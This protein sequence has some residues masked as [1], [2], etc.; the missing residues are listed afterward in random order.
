MKKPAAAAS[1]GRDAGGPRFEQE[2]RGDLDW[3][4]EWAQSSCGIVFTDDKV[5]QLRVRVRT[6]CNQYA[7]SL[8]EIR[9]QVQRG[10]AKLTLALADAVSTNYTFFLRE[11]EIFRLLETELFGRLPPG[12]ELRFWSAA[13]ASGDEAYSLAIVAHDYF[14]GSPMVVKVLGTDLSQ[15]QVTL[16]ER[17]EYSANQLTLMPE[18]MRKRWFEPLPR[19]RWRANR[20]LRE[21][22]MFRRLNLLGADWPFRQRFHLIFL[23]NVLFYFESD[24]KAELLRRCHRATLPGGYLITSLTEPV[25]EL[26]TLHNCWERVSPAVYRRANR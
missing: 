14:A 12:P 23:R 26:D 22:C 24:V 7:L 19:N 3:L 5:E 15:Q 8:P 17:G 6:M 25:T 18:E 9:T 4:R 1:V 20:K 16:A 10:N 11:P 2:T 13:A 21:L